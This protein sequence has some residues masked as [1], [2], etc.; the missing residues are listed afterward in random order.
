[1]DDLYKKYIPD[2][3]VLAGSQDIFPFQEINNPADADGDLTVPSDLPYACD[4]PYSK[5]IQSFT[6][7]TRVVGRIPDVPGE[8]DI[9]IGRASC[10]ERV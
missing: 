7:P 6:G 5:N 1:M 3:I 2:Y 8:N 9:Q 4:A 10:R